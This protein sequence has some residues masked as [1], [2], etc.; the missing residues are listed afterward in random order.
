METD[1]NQR[2]TKADKLASFVSFGNLLEADCATE[3]ETT[4]LGSQSMSNIGKAELTE[5]NYLL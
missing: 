4:K 3:K 2:G 5:R 1:L